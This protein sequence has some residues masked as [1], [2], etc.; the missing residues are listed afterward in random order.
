MFKC[1]QLVMGAIL[2][3]AVAFSSTTFADEAEGLRIAKERKA[4]DEGWEDSS[5]NTTMILRNAN[6]QESERELRVYTLEVPEQGDKSLTVF[7]SPA[8]IKGTAFLSFSYISEPDDQWMYLPK[9]KRVKRISTQ[10]KSGPFMSSEFAYEDMSSFEIDKFKFDFVKTDTFE[11]QQ[12][13]VVEQVPTDQFSGY[14]K[15]VVYIDTQEY[16]PLKTDYY[17]KK[18]SLL[19][20]LVLEDYKLYSDKYW[21]PTASVMTN[22]QTGKST[23]LIINEISLKTGEVDERN[24]DENRLKRVR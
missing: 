6:G 15:Q 1:N 9:L 5:A 12:V 10:N 19:K 7:D 4:R 24:F 13:Y 20:T 23:T 17:D 16:R 21:R 11:G 22:V 14:S 3:V 18:G 2:G 8:D